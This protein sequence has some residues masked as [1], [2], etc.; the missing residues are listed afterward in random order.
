[1]SRENPHHL[2]VLIN[3]I[4]WMVTLDPQVCGITNDMCAL[5]TLYNDHC[6]MY[7]HTQTKTRVVING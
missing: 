4:K 6:D 3:V 7:M 2:D 5:W 1:M